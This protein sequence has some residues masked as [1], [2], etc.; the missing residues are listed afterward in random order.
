VNCYDCAVD[1][2]AGTAVAA[3]VDCG[4]GICLDHS[5]QQRRWLARTLLFN[6]VETVHP[7]ARQI[8][9]L[10]CAAAQQAAT[11]IPAH[12]RSVGASR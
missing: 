9:C 5:T 12:R 2:V 11:T 7:A 6:R 8:R 4:A 1:G 10:T 3:C